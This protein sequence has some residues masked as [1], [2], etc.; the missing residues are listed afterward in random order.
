M[1][2]ILMQSRFVWKVSIWKQDSQWNILGLVNLFYLLQLK[3]RRPS[4]QYQNSKR[5]K[6]WRKDGG[7]H[8]NALV[9]QNL[10]FCTP[11]ILCKQIFFVT[12]IPFFCRCC[13]LFLKEIFVFLSKYLWKITDSK[14]EKRLKSLS[15]NWDFLGLGQVRNR[16]TEAKDWYLRNAKER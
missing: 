7:V 8:Q 10:Y 3:K 4:L 16:K 6:L 11:N 2:T 9:M 12:D 5:Y 13:G 1:I 15:A 14:P